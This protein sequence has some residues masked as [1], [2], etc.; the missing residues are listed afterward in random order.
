[1]RLPP[2]VE[3]FAGGAAYVAAYAVLSYGHLI[4]TMRAREKQPCAA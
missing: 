4:T 1:L 3:L 2:L